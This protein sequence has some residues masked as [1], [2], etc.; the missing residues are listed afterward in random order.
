VPDSSSLLLFGVAALA[1]IMVPGPNV[2][3]I[4]TRS[5]SQGRRTGLVSVLG[6]QAGTFVHIGAAA[7]GLS[8]LLAS[9]AAA[10]N[11]VKYLGAAYL[12]YL[13]VRELMS[14][15][16]FSVDR[17]PRVRS[18]RRVFFQGALIN[19]LNPKVALFFLAFLPQFLDLSEGE[20]TSQILVLGTIFFVLGLASDSVYAL[21][22][23]SLGNWLQRR[24]RFARRQRY[25]AG[26]VYLALGVSAA[27][28]NVGRAASNAK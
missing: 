9:S 14:D 18:M 2:I 5:V 15:R 7:L 6:V 24:P 28:V 23:G 12:V 13:G 11:I 10:L 1:L 8:A 4:V 26:V 20:V 16:A 19:A 3:Y 27:F 17:M 21:V 22:A 25:A